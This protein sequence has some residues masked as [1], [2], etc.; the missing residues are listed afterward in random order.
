MTKFPEGE[1]MV[2]GCRRTRPGVI[3]LL[4]RVGIVMRWRR[5]KEGQKE[6]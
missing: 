6:V 2:E 1:A 4:E 3:S 5:S